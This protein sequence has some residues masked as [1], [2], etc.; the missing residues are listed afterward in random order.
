MMIEAAHCM[1]DEQHFE[2][3]RRLPLWLN[4]KNGSSRLNV[5]PPPTEYCYE[6]AQRG[7]YI[8]A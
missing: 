1:L 7:F 5:L 4:V 3:T 2:L 6:L 8:R